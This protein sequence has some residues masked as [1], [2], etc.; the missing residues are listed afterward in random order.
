MPR[1]KQERNVAKARELRRE[2]SLPEVLLWRL[3]RGSPQGV[4]FRRQ[5]STGIYFLDFYC[6]SA[7]LAIEIDGIAHDMGERPERDP[8]RDVWLAEQGFEVVRI[9]ASDVLRS[10]EGVAEALVTYCKRG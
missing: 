9:P 1:K 2:M 7:N 8:V 10:P 6:A 5:H 3:L 4:K